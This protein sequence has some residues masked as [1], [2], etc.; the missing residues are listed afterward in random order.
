MVE[1]RRWLLA[2]ASL[3]VVLGLIS[4]AGA[5]AVPSDGT[6]DSGFGI[7]GVGE[8]GPLAV[9]AQ[10]TAPA[11]GRPA[12]LFITGTLPAGWHTYSITQ[13]EPYLPTKIKL[14]ES[15][16]YRVL[17]AFQS[18][19]APT[20]RTEADGNITENHEGTFTWYAPIEVAGNVDPATLSIEGKLTVQACGPR[21][22]EMPRDYPFTAKLGTGVPVT[23]VVAPPAAP[24]LAAPPIAEP[25]APPVPTNPPAAELPGAGTAAPG[26]VQ[27]QRVKDK[28][29]LQ[30]NFGIDAEQ[31][32]AYL[33]GQVKQSSVGESIGWLIA[34]FFGGLILNIMPCV[35]PVI[36][37]KILSFVE[38]SGH[39]RRKAFLLNVWYS[40]GLMSVF[41]VL[42]SL[43]VLFGFGWG[44][45]FT[46]QGFDIALAAVVFV[47][48]LSFLGVWELPIP[49]FAGRG[50]GAELASQEGA[51]GAFFKGVM[52]TVLATPCSAPLLGPALFWGTKQPPALTYAVFL[53]TGIGMASPYLLIGAF[54]ALVRFLPKPGAWMDTFKHAMG[55]VLLGT[56]WFILYSSVSSPM[57]VP[58]L[59]LLFGLW[60]SCWWIGRISPLA[61]TPAK[62]RGW[63]QAIAF[64]AVIWV[65]MFPGI[66]KIV[67]G[68]FGFRGVAEMSERGDGESQALAL[69]SLLPSKGPKTPQTVLVDFTA[70]WCLTCK[71]LEKTVLN[72]QDVVDA[73]RKNRVVTLQGDWT[74]GDPGVTEMLDHMLLSKQV[75]VVAIFSARDP[76]RPVV[77]YGSYTP[78]GLLDALEKAGPSL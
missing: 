71:T 73:L 31:V 50:K 44:Q 49:G 20:K 53:A 10:F 64:S 26:Q 33:L 5:Q 8:G 56:V 15:P 37:L 3:A 54:P 28:S 72:R 41:V 65:L 6:G 1:D 43:T 19:P 25:V 4:L 11:A 58:T 69:N 39:D 16:R 13:K 60:A 48:G 9:Q 38:Q 66:D 77:F 51:G 35:L 78:Q 45:L 29:E 76:N 24:P 75:P 17:G 7:G 59:G 27:W 74:H 70:D 61:E 62:V 47:M 12:R 18:D 30:S 2:V 57:V 22:C 40:L 34:A 55:F 52:S 67:P 63:F 21:G 23:A 36:G 32:R 14:T 68:T 42:G 46:Y